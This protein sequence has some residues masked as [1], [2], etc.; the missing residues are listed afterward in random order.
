M[1]KHP[2]ANWGFGVWQSGFAVGITWIYSFGFREFGLKVLD[3]LIACRVTSHELWGFG[4]K[5]VGLV[6][7]NFCVL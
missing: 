4:C 3:L 6:A 2:F 7:H 1:L 5:A